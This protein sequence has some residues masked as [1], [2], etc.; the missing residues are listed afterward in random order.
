MRIPISCPKCG[1]IGKVDPARLPRSVTCPSCR[2]VFRAAV[3]APAP[4][5]DIDTTPPANVYHPRRRRR[6]ASPLVAALVLIA[7]LA[8]YRYPVD[9]AAVAGRLGAMMNM[10]SRFTPEQQIVYDYLMKGERKYKQEP[11][12]EFLRW[13][14]PADPLGGTGSPMT[15]GADRAV[16]AEVRTTRQVKLFGEHE[17]V[18]VREHIFYLKGDKVIA[19]YE[20]PS[21]W[22]DYGERHWFSFQVRRVFGDTI[23]E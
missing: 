16:W 9:P 13:G 6:M 14:G 5:L 12:I 19:D 3:P 20:E 18:A 2:T 11:Q 17:L 21:A 1:R 15:S 10:F 22:A 7:G 8:M 23:D 4:L